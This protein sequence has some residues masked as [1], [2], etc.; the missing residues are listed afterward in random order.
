MDK[1]HFKCHHK[2][3]AS[4]NYCKARGDMFL[5]PFF[6]FLSIQFF[7]WK[8]LRSR[9]PTFLVLVPGIAQHFERNAIMVFIDPG[10][11]SD[12]KVTTLSAS[13]NRINRCCD[14]RAFHKRLEGGRYFPR[15]ML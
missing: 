3:D 10:A 11:L 8:N 4:L 5:L 1:C 6:F 7:I 14:S 2:K 12:S 13:P 15:T 9:I